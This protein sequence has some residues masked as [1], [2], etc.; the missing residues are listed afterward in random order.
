M[1]DT[2]V[3]IHMGNS[4]NGTNHEETSCSMDHTASKLYR[5]VVWCVRHLSKWLIGISL[6]IWAGFYQSLNFVV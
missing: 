5:I 3:H 1:V 4:K 6:F 2:C